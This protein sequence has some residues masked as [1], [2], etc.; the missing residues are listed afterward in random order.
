MPPRTLVSVVIPCYNPGRF[1]EQTLASVRAQSY[2]P[3]ETILVDDG[4]DSPEGRA[5]LGSLAGRVTR[6]IQQP[7]RGLPA[8]RNAGF[9]AAAGSYVLPLD[10]DDR[11]RPSFLAGCVAA[12]DADREAAFV[13]TDYRFFG[14]QEVVHRLKDYNLFDLLDQNGMA[15]A[16]LIRRAEWQLA[17]GYDE[18][19]R[20][21]YEDWDF[22]LRLGEL[23]RFGHHLAAVL[24]EYRK[25]GPSLYAAALERHQELVE[26][27]H[28]NHP[29]LYSPEG[30][31]RIKTCWAPSVCLLSDREPAEEQTI[32]DV[33]VLAE[34]DPRRALAASRAPAFLA[35][36]GVALD[37]Q[38]AELSALA[39]WSGQE[40]VMLPDGA[41]G[42]SRK[43]L[44]GEGRRTRWSDPL[45][46]RRP[47]P[48]GEARPLQYLTPP[49]MGKRRVALVTRHLGSGDAATRLLELA[50]AIDRQGSEL[51]VIA[52]DSE[53]LGWREIWQKAAD[54]VY[55]LPPLVA[56]GR[57]TDVLYW[58]A[59]NW[60]FDILVI[61]NSPAGYGVIRDLRKA[62]PGV[63]IIE[64]IRAVEPEW[65]LLSSVTSAE[66]QPDLRVVI[67]EAGRMEN[68][69]DLETRPDGAT[70]TVLL[71]G[72]RLQDVSAGPDA[73]F[74]AGHD[75]TL[76][77]LHPVDLNFGNW[78]Q[79]KALR[80]SRIE[81]LVTMEIQWRRLNR[82]PRPLRCFV[83]V[84][85][86]GGESLSSMDHD[87]LGDRPP[88]TE[89]Q[90]GDEGYEARS[91]VLPAGQAREAQVRLGV[92]DRDS[93]V[94]APVWASTLPLVDDYTA[95]VVEPNR[96]PGSAVLFR[97]QPAGIE[98]CEVAFERGL[99]LTGWSLSR[100]AGAVWLRLRWE[101]PRRPKGR[102]RFFGHAVPDQSPEA[103][104]L[105]SFD[106][107][108]RF[109]G[110]T[111]ICD[112]VRRSSPAGD[113]VKFLR[114]GVVNL[115][116]P[117][118]RLRIRSSSLP[119]SRQQKAVYLTLP[120]PTAP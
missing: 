109:H 54:H 117:L 65:N 79:V 81:G 89:W 29:Q 31:A 1:L 98:A 50:R 35:P 85:G 103:P 99:R 70:R 58:M 3:L 10:A 96:D 91:V 32:L 110:E 104:I 76:P 52:A 23:G 84:V 40:E 112:I 62:L 53:D 102:L 22:W 101:A 74:P 68:I 120:P 59:R 43:A 106:E 13:Y 6:V 95:A 63:K 60:R 9:R 73:F 48:A 25:H 66:A 2:R 87:I 18:R 113:P 21:G 72:G 55:D 14:D 111:V 11:I 38:S 20:W 97:M 57:A 61:Q 82:V 26:T 33:Q 4:T 108:L 107:D 94:R 36:S 116:R 80:L 64:L 8:A 86:A 28:A 24:F 42:V 90:P 5:L 119:L 34:G 37:R 71:A 39:I 115:D 27:I 114:A 15:Y 41:R 56:A 44:A 17:G 16:S 75:A 45:G 47:G 30:R 92:Y 7:N 93:M 100:S 78:L 46:S 12:L 77:D 88:V 67:S 51:F 83:H 69:L 118:E 19:M 105:S 49:P